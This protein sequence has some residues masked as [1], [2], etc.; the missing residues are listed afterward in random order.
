MKQ[1]VLR[2]L[3]PCLWFRHNMGFGGGAVALHTKM[4]AIILLVPKV[5]TFQ[6]FVLE[7][8]KGGL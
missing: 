7:P 2:D 6:T 1:E 4:T 3:V 8:M 5:E